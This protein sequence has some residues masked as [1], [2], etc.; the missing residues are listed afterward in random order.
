MSDGTSSNILA[1]RNSGE[2]LELL[3]IRRK[4]PPFPGDLALPGG[5]VKE[6]ETVEDAALR[7][8][9]K[10]TNIS[11]EKSKLFSLSSRTKVGRDPRGDI[12]G[13]FFMFYQKEFNK[14][15]LPGDGVSEVGWVKIKDLPE[16]A[17]DHGSILCEAIGS[18]WPF[19]PGHN[20][21][22]LKV[23]LPSIF[24]CKNVNAKEEL[25]FFGGS[26]N[27][28]H[29]GHQACVDLCPNNNLVIIPDFNP[30]KSA[31]SNRTNCSWKSYRDLAIEMEKAPYAIYPGFWGK[32]LPNPTVEWLPK[33]SASRKELLLGDDSY[34]NILKWKDSKEVLSS[35]QRLY[36]VPRDHSESDLGDPI[37]E[38]KKVNSNIVVEKLSGHNYQKISSSEIRS[39]D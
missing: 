2:E 3:V 5:F 10:E 26:F 21:T 18:F 36:V 13:H 28:W 14:D 24:S 12:T 39:K 7:E 27:P 1:L 25:V 9:E 17:F 8:F 33:T 20:K 31:E 11:L 30:W 29:E 4:F 38:L 15:P 34:K 37:L 35:V 22:F 32:E 16:L 6:N 23:D 19:M